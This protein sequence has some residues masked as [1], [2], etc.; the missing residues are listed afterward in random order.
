MVL[1]PLSKIGPYPL[2]KSIDFEDDFGD[3]FGDDFRDDFGDDFDDDCRT[4]FL[5][6]VL[7]NSKTPVW[8]FRK[9]P[10]EGGS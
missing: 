9:N 3:D 7:L 6:V 2:S 1:T 4:R 8:G 5:T 10:L